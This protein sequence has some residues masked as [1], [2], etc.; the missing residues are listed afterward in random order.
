MR[1]LQ[2]EQNLQ[3][4]SRD[5]SISISTAENKYSINLYLHAH[6]DTLFLFASTSSWLLIELSYILL[7][8]YI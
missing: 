8:A 5:V 1:S 6:K 4:E 2:F 7:V 3:T